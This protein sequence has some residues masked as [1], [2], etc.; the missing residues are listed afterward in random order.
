MVVTDLPEAMETI[1]SNIELNGL[2]HVSDSIQ[3]D[4][5]S[6]GNEEDVNRISKVVLGGKRVDYIIAADCVYWECLF[7]PFAETLLSYA[8]SGAR[9]IIAH[10]R[11]WKKDGKFFDLCK[12]KGMTVE[13]LEELVGVDINENTGQSLRSIK[14]I[15][16][17]YK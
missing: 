11:R 10:V 7:A 6:W 12:R 4:V 17:I 2:D 16:Q 9:I 1:S 14:R 5:L 15:Y 3:A 8:N 13:V